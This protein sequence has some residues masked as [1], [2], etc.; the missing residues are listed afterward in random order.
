MKLKLTH[1][2]L[3]FGLVLAVVLFLPPEASA[4]SP[5]FN[6]AG[7]PSLAKAFTID[8][9]EVSK[10]VMGAIR[11]SGTV[12]YYQIVVPAG[13]AL[14]VS[15]FVP[16][17]CEGFY[18]QI[19]SIGVGLETSR[20]SAS[21]EVPLGLN[22]QEF[23]LP[24]GEWG[25]YFEPFDPAFYHAGPKISIQGHPKTQYLAIYSAEGAL[26][27]YMLG[28]SGAESWQPAENWRARKAAYDRCEIGEAN[29]FLSRWR[30]LVIGMGIVGSLTLSGRFFIRRN[31]SKINPEI[32]RENS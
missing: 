28:T 11:R 27:A 19:T 8:D 5:V 30:D 7:S 1:R 3:V 14:H 15:L 12:D 25:T 31:K 13:Q 16:A 29:W 18:P 10:A 2:W 6:D 21:L 9:I 32:N 17:A 22:A 24:A 23:K 26:G 20:P 4:H